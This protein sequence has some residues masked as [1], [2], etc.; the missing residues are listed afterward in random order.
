M[1]RRRTGEKRE[2]SASYPKQQ[3]NMIYHMV[4]VITRVAEHL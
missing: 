2:E 4:V 3:L 1:R